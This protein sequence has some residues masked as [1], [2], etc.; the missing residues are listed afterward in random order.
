[1]T[2]SVYSLLL[3]LVT[4][5]S[6][7]FVL[8]ILRISVSNLTVEWQKQSNHASLSRA[9]ESGSRSP[10]TYLCRLC[11][12]RSVARNQRHQCLSSSRALRTTIFQSEALPHQI[13]FRVRR[14]APN[15]FWVGRCAPNI[16]W[17]G[18]CA[19]KYVITHKSHNTNY[20]RWY[21]HKFSLFYNNKLTLPNW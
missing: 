10:Q 4:L 5:I 6:F 1:M 20:Y 15:I 18:R 11:R 13:L 3:S 14:C 16:F 7:A 21:F 9:R 19:P 2:L 8:R 17:V 12:V